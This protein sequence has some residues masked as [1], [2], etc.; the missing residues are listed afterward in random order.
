MSKSKVPAQCYFAT[1]GA[2]IE[3]S[4]EEARARGLELVLPD[5]L[6]ILPVGYL[7]YQTYS[8][9]VM[10]AGKLQRNCWQIVLYRMDS[11]RYELT[12]YLM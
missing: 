10:K 7:E 8:I 9:D 4:L 6:W 11:G 1:Q 12:Q 3:A 5:R 2:A